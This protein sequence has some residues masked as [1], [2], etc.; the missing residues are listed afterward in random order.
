MK[1]YEKEKKILDASREYFKLDPTK[2]TNRSPYVTARMMIYGY[3]R[4]NT[5]WPL[6]HI[7]YLF[8]VDHSTVINGLRNH[9][10]RME[11]AQVP[12]YRDYIKRYKEFVVY[13]DSVLCEENN[14][15]LYAMSMMVDLVAYL[16]K[17]NHSLEAAQ[18]ALALTWVASSGTENER[19][20]AMQSSDDVLIPNN[21]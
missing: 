15:S 9:S 6:K 3:L 18:A 1:Q 5:T 2:K 8:G 10:D 19:I 21:N 13:M 17:T 12:Y 16:Q 4:A 20:E 14:L 11:S 7:G